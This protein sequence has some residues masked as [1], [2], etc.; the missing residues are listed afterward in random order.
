M[1]N[2]LGSKNRDTRDSKDE[3]IPFDYKNP[4]T[5]CDFTDGG[6]ISPSHA[7][8]LRHSEQRKLRN[9]IKKARNIGLVPTS[10][11]AYDDFGR[12]PEPISPKPFKY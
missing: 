6:K 8:N 12:R 9:A 1:K 2:F 3:D 7:T 5:V 11:Q 4:L 10:H